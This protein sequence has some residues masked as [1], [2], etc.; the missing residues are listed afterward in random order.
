MRIITIN[1]QEEDYESNKTKYDLELKKARAA[2]QD[3]GLSDIK[4]YSNQYQAVV[5]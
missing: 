1:D 2:K 5:Q 4:G 3:C